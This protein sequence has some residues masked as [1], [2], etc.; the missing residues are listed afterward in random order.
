MRVVVIGAGGLLGTAFRR[1]A[2]EL[3]D[4]E[5]VLPG[6]RELDV[7]DRLSVEK[8]LISNGPDGVVNAA[9]LL[10]ADLCETHPRAA[11]E[12]H[13]LGARWVSRA[14][15]RI[16]AVSAYISTDFVFDG[17]SPDG[18]A[19]DSPTSPVLTYG[20]TKRAGEVE[21]CLGTARHLVLRTA[22]LFG[23]PPTGSRARPCFVDRILAQADAGRPVGVVDSVVMSPTYTVD[24][25]RMTFAMLLD[26]AAPGVYH[27]VN[28]GAASWY[29]VAA[30]AVRL[31]GRQV[32]VARQREQTHVAA[33]RPARTPLTGALPG[34]A[35]AHQRPWQEA[36]AEYVGERWPAPGGRPPHPAAEPSA[37]RPHART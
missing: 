12:I 26:E 3:P 9:A 35:A 7:T 15:D 4:V 14:C 1:V 36:L 33:G 34:R 21:A 17:T 2:G 6:R 30:T 20:V 37:T 11:Y 24:L 27:A 28:R 10:P 22:G 25:A 29:D 31:S 23:P 5:V 13:A 32:T 16:G 8:Y 19:P 18:Y